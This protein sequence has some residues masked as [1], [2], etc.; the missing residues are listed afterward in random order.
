MTRTI[1]INADTFPLRQA[2]AIARGTKVRAEPISVEIYENGV[3]GHGEALPYPRYGETVETVTAT[4]DQLRGV[5]SDGLSRDDLQTAL[6]PGAARC[7]RCP[8][9]PVGQQTQA[10]GRRRPRR[11]S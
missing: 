3:R 8:F 7:A 9:A 10:L 6:Q 5:L 1:S 4:I 2:F 11:R